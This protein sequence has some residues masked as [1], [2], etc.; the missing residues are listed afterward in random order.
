MVLWKFG[1]TLHGYEGHYQISNLGRVKSLERKVNYNNR[2]RTISERILSQSLNH[3]GYAF[4]HLCLNQKRKMKAV[5]RLV[6]IAFIPNPENKPQVNHINGIKTDNRVENLEWCTGDENMEHAYKTG[7]VH[8]YTKGIL[9]YDLDGNIL[10]KWDSIN[11]CEKQLNIHQSNIV[12][13]AKGRIPT[14]GG[15]KWKYLD[16]TTEEEK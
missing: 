2:N 6:A 1:K 10:K 12:A 11:E 7:L 14:A 16:K 9:Q 3:K 5:H 15:Y 13:C 8:T 4:A